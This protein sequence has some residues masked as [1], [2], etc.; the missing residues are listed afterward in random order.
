MAGREIVSSDDEPVTVSFKD[1][2][3]NKFALTTSLKEEHVKA[4]R[5]AMRRKNFRDPRFD[6]R[7]NGVCVLKHWKELKEERVEAMKVAFHIKF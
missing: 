7:V 1:L 5:E 2:K 6:P 4:K 3:K